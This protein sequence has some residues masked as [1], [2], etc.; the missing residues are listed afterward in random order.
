MELKLLHLIRLAI[1][2][3]TQ[4]YT[5]NSVKYTIYEYYRIFYYNIKYNNV[6]FI[7]FNLQTLTYYTNLFDYF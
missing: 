4:N 5:Y 7:T 2:I 1:A 6:Y 3:A